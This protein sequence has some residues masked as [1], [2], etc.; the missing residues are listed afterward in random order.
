M[1]KFSFVIIL[2]SDFFGVD[3]FCKLECLL[4]I[5]SA[6][7]NTDIIFAFF[8]YSSLSICSLFLRFGV[9][10]FF[11]FIICGVLILRFNVVFN[12][13]DSLLLSIVF[14]GEIFT[15]LKSLVFNIL[16]LFSLLTLSSSSLLFKLIVFNF[17]GEDVSEEEIYWNK[18]LYTLS[19]SY[20]QYKIVNIIWIIK[21]I[22]I[23]HPPILVNSLLLK[24][25]L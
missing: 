1:F 14:I 23:I 8:K 11:K 6:K 16:L 19:I 20:L 21:K 18:N 22:K 15:L 7:L 12:C 3:W 24:T 25:F 4:F 10:I 13:V 9:E 2:F 5:F 17:G